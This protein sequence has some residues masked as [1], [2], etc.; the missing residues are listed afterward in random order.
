MTNTIYLW[1]PAIQCSPTTWGL[2]GNLRR[3]KE[4]QL[5]ENCPCTY[6]Q[7]CNSSPSRATGI[8]SFLHSKGCW[9]DSEASESRAAKESLPPPTPESSVE[10]LGKVSF[11]L[12][13]AQTW[14]NEILITALCW[15]LDLKEPIIT[16][17]PLHSLFHPLPPLFIRA[18]DKPRTF[19][20]SL[21]AFRSIAQ[22]LTL[23]T[24]EAV[25][26][27]RDCEKW[28]RLSTRESLGNLKMILTLSGSS[29]EGSGG[30]HSN[31]LSFSSC[32]FCRDTKQ[33]WDYGSN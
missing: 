11:L 29:G 24:T 3:K 13:R 25:L 5:H 26:T 33:R 27:V 19:W 12:G 6:T 32:K 28:N 1:T 14:H 17:C 18:A 2:R 21:K 16:Q 22:T 23:H 7:L 9:W 4:W 20:E 10:L 15:Q 31:F 8:E 30:R